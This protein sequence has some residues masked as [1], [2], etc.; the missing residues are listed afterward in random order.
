[1]KMMLKKLAL[2]AVL[3]F[4]TMTNDGCATLKRIGAG[5]QHL[6]DCECLCQCAETFRGGGDG[7]DTGGGTS[8]RCINKG[9]LS[10]CGEACGFQ[11]LPGAAGGNLVVCISI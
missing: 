10:S 3:V 11:A 2:V 6:F 4:A 7:T 1:M 9:S 8:F 5:I